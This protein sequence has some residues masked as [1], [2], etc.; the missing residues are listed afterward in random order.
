MLAEQLRGVAQRD[1]NGAELLWLAAHFSDPSSVAEGA[2]SGWSAATP[3][4]IA[5]RV[6]C[7]KNATCTQAPPAVR[8]GQQLPRMLA[9]SGRRH[10]PPPACL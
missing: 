8:T 1:F 4:V 10:S 3:G 7:L 6:T 9:T 5:R 2:P